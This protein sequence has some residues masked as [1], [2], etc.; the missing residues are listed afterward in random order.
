MKTRIITIL[1]FAICPRVSAA[2]TPLTTGETAYWTSDSVVYAEVVSVTTVRSNLVRLT[3]DVKA[4]L[5][6]SW[7]AAA[8]PSLQS[9]VDIGLRDS[10]VE[11]APS[12]KDRV[13][14]LVRKVPGFP[15][16]I[17]NDVVAYMPNYCAIVVVKSFDGPTVAK[18]V[19]RLREL[20]SDKPPTNAELL[21]RAQKEG[22]GK[23][24]TTRIFE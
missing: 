8:N 13:V 14:V 18:I 1:L 2:G 15:Y 6:G 19:S 16:R 12:V 4:T 20:R 23:R 17:P 11:Y 24:V 9:D 7:E 21:R 3:L 22:V 5:A 10:S